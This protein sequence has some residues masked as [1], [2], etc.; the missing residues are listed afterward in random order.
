MAKF[1]KFVQNTAGEKSPIQINEN[2]EA[3]EIILAK[4][5]SGVDAWVHNDLQ[6]YLHMQY[7][8][9]GVIVPY[10]TFGFR[11][12]DET[13]ERHGCIQVFAYAHAQLV[14]QYGLNGNGHPNVPWVEKGSCCASKGSNLLLPL[15]GKLSAEN[16]KT[17]PQQLSGSTL[18]RFIELDEATLNVAVSATSEQCITHLV[19]DDG[20]QVEITMKNAQGEDIPIALMHP[21]S[22]YVHPHIRQLM[23]VADR[24]S[25][26]LFRET[27]TWGFVNDAQFKGMVFMCLAPEIN[28]LPTT[29]EEYEPEPPL[30][31]NNGQLA[32]K[33]CP[34]CKA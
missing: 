6:D 3:V 33:R 20:T 16:L 14:E 10:F 24:P 32:K 15:L 34:A 1:A 12:F 22:C 11:L 4:P 8:P 27:Y 25:N 30:I 13:D 28:T 19:K 18:Y 5:E 29:Y 21:M 7:A 26:Q 17:L 2:G 31:A 23:H 9:L